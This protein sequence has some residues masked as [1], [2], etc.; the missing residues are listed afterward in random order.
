MSAVPADPRLRA[1][2]RTALRLGAVALA[3][4]VLVIVKYKVFGQ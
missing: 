2:R 4:F 3:F 1:N